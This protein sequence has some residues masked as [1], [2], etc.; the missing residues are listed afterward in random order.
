MAK[1]GK[2]DIGKQKKKNSNKVFALVVVVLLTI[3]FIVVVLKLNSFMG[4]P[5]ETVVIK[6][7]YSPSCPWCEKME[8][9][10]EKVLPEFGEKVVLEKKCVKIHEGDEYVC[11]GEYGLEEYNEF[12]K[13]AKEL[14][15]SGTPT[16]FLNEKKA[17]YMEEGKFREEV[18]YAL[19]G[20]LYFGEK[21]S[22]C[23]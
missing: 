6:Y 23:A 17:G 19:Y 14:E 8:I 4:Y 18:C 12:I 7:F 16:L 15:I 13:E 22:P 10:M 21:V 20:P 5:K 9:V 3:L 11:I 2:L 1:L